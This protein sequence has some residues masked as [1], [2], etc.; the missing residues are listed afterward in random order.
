MGAV[1]V[2]VGGLGAAASGAA[3]AAGFFFVGESEAEGQL[4]ALHQSDP[5]ID[6]VG[7]DAASLQFGDIDASPLGAAL[8]LA[9]Q[10]VVDVAGPPWVSR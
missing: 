5:E 2:G 1:G 3:I 9:C 6:P 10:A 7:Y 4:W 8:E